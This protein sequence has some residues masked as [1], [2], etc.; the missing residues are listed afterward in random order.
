MRSRAPFAVVAL[1]LAAALP[2]GSAAAAGPTKIQVTRTGATVS[3]AEFRD[4]LQVNTELSASSEATRDGV[5]SPFLYIVQ[6]AYAPDETGEYNILAW[7][8]E[9]NTTDF[10][11]TIDGQLASAT[12]SA[13]AMPVTRCDGDS[14]CVEQAVTVDATFAAVGDPQRS[15]DR[16]V[17]SI[18]RQSVFIYH[19]V[20]AYRFATA[21][22]TIGGSTYGP[23][24]GLSDAIIY[25]TKTGSIEVTKASALSRAVASGVTIYDTTGTPTGRQTGDS[26]FATWTS[27][28][29]GVGRNTVLSASTRQVNTKG[30]FVTTRSIGYGDQVYTI[31]ESGN[32]EIVTE[33][34][35]NFDTATATTISLDKSLSVGILAGATIP[36]TACTHVGD[37]VLCIDTT[38][39]ADAQWTGYGATTKTRDGSTGGVAGVVLI[40][41]HNAS[42]H[43]AATA[44]ATVDGVWIDPATIV[45][46]WV[47]RTTTGFHEVH[48]GG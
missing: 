39:V 48:L 13:P 12:V 41:Y 1:L 16:S 34:Y 11:M 43:R 33:T 28:H 31:D 36:A 18:S 23:S 14:N 30:I 19:D 9:G 10:T 35:G 45:E 22:V 40:V 25:D 47:D 5:T 20:G 32:V 15:H 26:M 37:E 44:S 29:D 46:G 24:M 4:G 38:V 8:V 42:S 27:E 6:N 17:G 21:T 2:V 7:Y 3:L